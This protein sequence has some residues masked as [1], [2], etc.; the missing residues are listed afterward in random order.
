[1]TDDRNASP[2]AKQYEGRTPKFSLVD[3]EN[4]TVIV[5]S[6]G[7]RR[8]SRKVNCRKKGYGVPDSIMALERDDSFYVFYL[9]SAATDDGDKGSYIFKRK[10]EIQ[11][12]LT[13]LMELGVK[14]RNIFL[15]GHSA[16]AW[17]SLMSMDVVGSKFNAAIAFAPACCGPR[18]EKNKYPI[19]RKE[20]RPEH[21]KTMLAVPRI[22]ALVF[23]YQRDKFNRPRDLQFLTD[24]FPKSV[25]LVDSDCGG[26]S[27]HLNSCTKDQPAKRIREY[28]AER[29]ANF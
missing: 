1:M 14:P 21:V 18:S 24:K 6:H 22:E 9:C 4:A 16:G 2:V 19:W 7:T 27:S 5:Y 11:G 25:V 26:H 13:E 23:A 29:K 17:S 3:P 15:A 12:V 8:P 28:I 20:I 10:K